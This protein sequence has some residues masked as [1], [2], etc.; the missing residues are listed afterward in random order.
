MKLSRA[1]LEVKLTSASILKSGK[2]S[3]GQALSRLVKSIHILHLPF[4]FLTNT[5]L[6]IQSG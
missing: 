6:A 1:C 2:L 4:F 3:L 5:T